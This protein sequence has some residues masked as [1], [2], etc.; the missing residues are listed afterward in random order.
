MRNEIERKFFIKEMPDI[1]RLQPVRYERYVLGSADEQEESR[2]SK[3]G[4]RYYFERK[5]IISDIERTTDKREIS[6]DEFEALKPGVGDAIV[7]DKY[8]LI[9]GTDTVSIQVYHGRFEG[10]IRAEV[11]FGSE[12]EAKRF[13]PPSWMGKEMTG[14]PVARDASLRNIGEEE[15]KR[16]LSESNIDSDL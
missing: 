12:E 15:F 14:L 1:S 5:R 13:V 6:Q 8:T 11:E 2:I 16:I 10:L 3:I 4:D 7:R 9:T